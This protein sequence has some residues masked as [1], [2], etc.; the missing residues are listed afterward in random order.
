M[1]TRD[2]VT[3][4]GQTNMEVAERSEMNNAIEL[5]NDLI[6]TNRG[7]VEIYETA[8]PHLHTE[9]NNDLLQ[10]Y[11]AQHH[12]YISELSNLVVSYGGTPNTSTN[13]NAVFKKIWIS[14]K[15]ALIAG[16]GHIIKEAAQAAENM[17]EHYGEAMNEAMPDAAR[18]MV[19]R[20]MSE[21]R[22]TYDKLS[23]LDTVYNS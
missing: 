12:A 15:A 10:R 23:A 9:A 3:V 7:L 14:L 6:A 4:R 11:A 20:Q 2:M 22:V 16:E 1:E 19:R 17:L 13:G 18:N 21:T 5:L 8:V